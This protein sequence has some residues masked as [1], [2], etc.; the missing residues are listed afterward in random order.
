MKIGKI[1]IND[2]IKAVKMGNREAER[3]LGFVCR[4]KVH[5]S[6]KIFSRKNYKIPKI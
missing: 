5:K 1:T 4:N 3:D 6:K 2:Y